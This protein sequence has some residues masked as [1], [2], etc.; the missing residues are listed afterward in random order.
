MNPLISQVRRHDVLR[1]RHVDEASADRYSEQEMKCPMSLRIPHEMIA[2]SVCSL[3]SQ[4]ALRV[5]NHPSHGYYFAIIGSLNAMEAEANSFRISDL[6]PFTRTSS[7][8]WRS[9]ASERSTDG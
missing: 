7:E 4:F 1:I 6:G 8:I 9:S 5:S 2:D 3:L